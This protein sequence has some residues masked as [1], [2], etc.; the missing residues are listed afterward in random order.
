MISFSEIKHKLVD[1]TLGDNE[2]IHLRRSI[3]ERNEDEVARLLV[4]LANT[5]GGYL[6]IGAIEQAKQC[7]I[8]GIPESEEEIRRSLDDT[9]RKYTTGLKYALSFENID[10][11]N[12]AIVGIYSSDSTVYYSRR[13]T[14]PERQIAYVR[15][16]VKNVATDK[17]F[18]K[19]VFK[20]MTVESFLLSLYG[21]S[22]RFQ[23]P[24]KWDD[25]FEQRFYCANYRIA[26]AAGNTPQLFATCVTRAKNSEAAWKVYAHGQ[27]LGAHCLQLEID[28]AELR[29]QLNATNY[30]IVE[31]QVDYKDERYILDLHLKKRSKNYSKYFSNFSF[32]KF[33]D[34]LT[35]KRDA[36]T[37]E[38]E[39]RLFAVPDMSV[40]TRN[41]WKKAKPLDIPVDWKKIINSVRIDK[42][43][44]AGELKAIQQACYN[45]GIDPVFKTAPVEGGI[46]VP[47]GAVQIV[48]ES[49][50]IDDMPGNMGIII[51]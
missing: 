43:C 6:V 9:I 27:G 23:E 45:A 38:Q 30:I 12:I 47:A 48:F 46:E 32:E 4:A 40:A 39:V 24:S 44:S 33:I 42:N 2:I 26:G 18:Y 21:H 20:Y 17:M 41:K 49:F 10:D 31:K 15:S 14:T 29:T 28:I 16:G 11:K 37:Y 13:E 8:V 25:R 3:S 22:W 1:K 7:I 19:R 35:L 51:K 50:D 36:Y 34:L 5:N